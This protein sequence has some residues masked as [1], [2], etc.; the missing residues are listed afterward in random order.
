[1]NFKITTIILLILGR[2]LL[3]GAN[4]FELLE[5]CTSL[6]DPNCVAEAQGIH[7]PTQQ[8]LAGGQE[9][10]Q[11]SSDP[12][13][14][15]YY[16]SGLKFSVRKR[17]DNP[18]ILSTFEVLY[19]RAE[20]ELKASHGSGIISSFYLQSKNLDEIDVAETFGSNPYAFQTNFFIK[21]NTST[22]DRGGYHEMDVPPMEEFH[23]YGIEWTEDKIVWLLD[24]EVIRVVT[25]DHPQ[26]F[27]HAP[28]YIK[29]SLWAGGDEL[30]E[31]GTIDWSGGRTNYEELPYTMYIKNLHVVDYST[32]FQHRYGDSL[33]D[34]ITNDNSDNKWASR[35]RFEITENAF[36]DFDSSVRSKNDKDS[37]YERT[38]KEKTT[39]SVGKPK[40]VSSEKY[41]Q[42]TPSD[43][44]IEETNQN[45]TIAAVSIGVSNRNRWI[46]M[47]E[48][49]AAELL[50]LLLVL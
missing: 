32:G 17:F 7:K 47:L 14:V 39:P 27:P 9:N 44:K 6:D 35:N 20:V 37:K 8:F 19:G 40:I 10:L 46:I 22:H 4:D 18:S 48:A 28:M 13:I 11:V 49:V 5:A 38:P 34:W 25:N 29:F 3:I 50:V 41:Q 2:C 30:N 31:P 23:K 24:G 33:E 16:D 43:T 45:N 26:G 15:Q 42:A 36:R 1:M 21:G 12:P